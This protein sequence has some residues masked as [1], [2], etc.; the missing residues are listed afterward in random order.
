MKWGFYCN[1][2]ADADVDGNQNGVDDDY[3]ADNGDDDSAAIQSMIFRVQVHDLQDILGVDREKMEVFILLPCLLLVIMMMI[4]VS[5]EP[6]ITI[7]F[8]NRLLVAEGLSLA[9]V[10]EVLHHRDHHKMMTIRDW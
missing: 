10:P 5:V 8:L 7:G 3:D 4:Q 2:D 1:H 9:V 6:G